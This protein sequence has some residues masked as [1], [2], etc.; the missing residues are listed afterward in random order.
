MQ[1]KEMRCFKCNRLLG[2]DLWG[3]MGFAPSSDITKA[4][5]DGVSIPPYILEIKC[6]NCKSHNSIYVYQEK[7]R[8]EPWKE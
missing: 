7:R 4:I 1:T 8:V 5:T 3:T 2:V 6:L